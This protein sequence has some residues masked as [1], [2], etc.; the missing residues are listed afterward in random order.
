MDMQMKV[1]HAVHVLNHDAE[2]CNRVA[3][4][5][6]LVQF[7]QTD[8]AWEV[9]ISILTSEHQ[10]YI[11]DFEVEFFA[12]QILKRKI[13]NEGHCLQLGVK[14]AL[15][16][17][18]LVAAKR[19]T[20]GPPQLLTQVCLALSALILR[21]AEHGK[22]IQQLFYS[23]QNLQS[24]DDGNVA[25]LE[26]LTVLPEEAIDTQSSD[27]KISPSHRSQYGQ[28]LLSHI[29]MV[30][31]FLLQQ[32]EKR[33]EDDVQLQEKNRK[34]LRCLLS[35]VRVGCFSEIPQG[36]L[37]A[38]PLLNFVFNSLQV[39][40]SFDLAIEVLTELVSCHEGLPQVLLC[41]VPFLKE[42]LLLPALA[43]G[44]EKI[45]AGLA[46]LMSEIG[47][48]APSLI[49]EASAE[50]LALTDALLSCVAFPS[51]GWEIAD[52]TLQFWSTLANCIL[53]LDMESR[54]RKSV[55]DMFFSIF[56]ALLDA[57]LLRAQVD[58]S[59]VGDDSGTIDLPDGLVQF[60]MNL[61]ELLVD[62]CQLLRPLTFTQKLLFSGWLSANVPIN[63]KEVET[64][65][66][67]LNAVSE[68]VLLDGQTFD[69]SMIVQLVAILSSSPSES[70]KG[71]ICIVYRSLAD[72][73]GSYSKWIS[74]FQNNARP[75]LLFLAAGISEPLS[76]N[77]C[78][79][80]L[81]KFCEDASAVI[82][83]PS[84]LEI[85]IWIGEA[86]EKRHLP[87]ED[88]VE[89]VSAI[90]A[91]L[92]SV[93]N[94]EL[95]NALLTRLLSSSYE[96]V[97]KLIDDDNH[98]LRQNPALYTQVLNSATRGLHRMGIVF[99]HLISPLPSEPSSDDPIL[100]LLRIFWPMLEKLFRSEHMENGSLSAAA[101][102]ALSLAIQSSGQQCIVLL[103][104]IL[105][106]LSTNFLSFQSHDCYVRTASVVIEEFGHK[107]EYAPLFI[108]TFER[109]TQA[110][111]VMGLNS[112]YIC[113]QEPD[114]VEAYTN[115]A[116]IFVR[117]TR[118]EVLAASGAILEISF[119]KAAIW[120][121]AM[122]RGAALAAMSY[123]SCFLEIGLSSLLESEGSFST[124]AIHVISHSGEGLVS[125]IV[126]ALLGVSAM[127][128]VHKCATILQQLAA[129]CSLSE[130]TIWKAILGWES[131][132][133]WLL[134]AVQA[135]PVEYLRQGEVE[136]LVP[137]WLNA[138]G[139]AASDYL[140][141]KSC[142]GV[143][144][145][146]GHMQGKG[147]RVLKRLI[148]EF[149]DGHRNIPNLT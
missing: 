55:E 131:L 144:S 107:E 93:S 48:A 64:K 116:S 100:G 36:S 80:A 19:F 136:T 89:I 72:V 22:P 57:L 146:Y 53:G 51:E 132:H 10:P 82:Y 1:A 135:L 149:A 68:V 13:Q 75:L 96:A 134:A 91:I 61:L 24:Q 111:S 31:E 137:I 138:L 2:S 114:L 133:A 85:L 99:S 69:F 34:I 62:I 23:L 32:S 49:A 40:L 58:E 44:D 63:W 18:L 52:S 37:A 143:K 20:S 5:Q 126:Y 28:E 76:S 104:K 16:N 67:A 8:A 97:K 15:L 103:P 59:T 142:N 60:R 145:D 147:G 77:A 117:G 121:T 6:W 86:L 26:M 38:H 42:I 29:P 105:D 87:L 88:E 90:S 129:I 141:S 130:R 74:T 45:I 113:D 128:R 98:S 92:G 54:N 14:D 71:F 43:N 120:C 123:L 12:A 27:C 33:F 108:T 95:Q 4:N 110:S 79:S 124:I 119:Q 39:S 106:W 35:W 84:N 3:A 30:L 65:L 148:R 47:Q 41:R 46:C 101:C 56:S 125:N 127:S 78:A 50:A 66:F 25:V 140:E 83:E 81:R 21:A 118:K 7:Q 139:G 112:S 73:I 9:A 115:F 94:R 102:R 11:S 109:F 17:A 122:H 70:I